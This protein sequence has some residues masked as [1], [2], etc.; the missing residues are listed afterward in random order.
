MKVM[1]APSQ[2]NCFLFI[3]RC[4]S[5]LYKESDITIKRLIGRCQDNGGPRT[6]LLSIDARFLV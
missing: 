3:Y 2:L 5:S 1:S 6:N 4:L